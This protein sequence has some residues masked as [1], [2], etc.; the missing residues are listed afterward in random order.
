M[1]CRSG[2]RSVSVCV[3]EGVSILHV[4]VRDKKTRTHTH[5]HIAGSSAAVDGG[6]SAGAAASASPGESAT[7]GGGGGSRAYNVKN[8]G[9]EKSVFGRLVYAYFRSHAVMGHLVVTMARPLKEF[10]KKDVDLDT[11]PI[12]VRI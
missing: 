1:G 12:A 9:D 3:R 11:N 5:T 2:C 10:L 6:D 8:F 7:D 4:K